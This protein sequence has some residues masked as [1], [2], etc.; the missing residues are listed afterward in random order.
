MQPPVVDLLARLVAIPSVNPDLSD[1]P[2][3]RGEHRL[4]DFLAAHL[5]ALGFA[6][7]RVGK[8]PRRTNVIG[9]FGP[10]RPRRS[11]LVEAHLDTQGVTGMTVAPF[12]AE[13]RDGRLYGRGACDTKGPMAAVLAALDADVL[14]AVAASGWQLIFVGAIGEETGNDGANELTAR[15]LGADEAVILE[16]T[17]L[18]VVHAHKG[19]LW[20]ELEVRGRAGHGS[21]PDR[22]L[23]AVIGMARAIDLI[24]QQADEDRDRR[25]HPVLGQTTVNIGVIRGGT[26]INII[27]DSCTIRVDRRI[28]PGDNQEAILRRLREGL[29]ALQAEGWMLSSDIR[30]IK[31]GVPFETP[32]DSSLIQRLV[33]AGRAQGVQT[34]TEGAGWFSDA[35]P[36][37]RTCRHVAV[38]GPGHIAQAHTVDEY[39]DLNELEAGRRVFREFLLR[40][41]A[42][43]AVG[44]GE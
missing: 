9:R 13:I 40:T 14:A 5:G 38:F 17:G 37:S 15:E 39:I 26:A 25:T 20:F 16:P 44:T 10:A 31:A 30:L 18:N 24:M 11:L 4:A 1:D 32:A 33:A 34:G 2:A 43:A 29:Q 21:N 12:G 42:E 41:A 7:E 8:D 19:A 28:L 6:V 22:G 35:G 23:N 3:I 36:F 27:P